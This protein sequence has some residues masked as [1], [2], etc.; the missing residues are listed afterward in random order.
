MRK[1]GFR[2]GIE[3]RISDWKAS[4]LTTEPR[5]TD[6]SQSPHSPL[7]LHKWYSYLESHTWQTTQAAEASLS[8]SLLSYRQP[9]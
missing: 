6:K 7:L 9:A 8:H 5:L 4:A 2:P 1:T 3:L